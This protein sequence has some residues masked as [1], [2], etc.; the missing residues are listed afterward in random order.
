M[1]SV[2][3]DEDDDDVVVD[4]GAGVGVGV[5][6]FDDVDYICVFLVMV[7]WHLL[8]S[9]LFHRC[10]IFCGLDRCCCCCRDCCCVVVIVVVVFVF[11]T[12][13]NRCHSVA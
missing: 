4:V 13:C 2:L 10:N 11:I 1:K 6:S 8:P 3:D 9:C 7:R 12:V 5:G